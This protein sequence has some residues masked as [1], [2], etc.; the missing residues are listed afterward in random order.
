[1]TTLLIA[2]WKNNVTEP[3]QAT[4]LFE[5]YRDAID[6][7]TNSTAM[8]V[9]CPSANLIRDLGFLVTNASYPDRLQLGSQDIAANSADQE[10]GQMVLAQAGT[11]FVIIGH[12][13]RRW[14][15]GES[16][17]LVNIKLKTALANGFTP[18]VCCGEVTRAAGWQETLTMQI[19]QTLAGIPAKDVARCLIA[20]EPVWAI[21]DT[22]GAR[23]DEPASAAESLALISQVLRDNLA[24]EPLGYLY[25]GSVNKT[26]VAG[27][28]A[29]PAVTGVLVGRAS[30]EPDFSE[31]INLGFNLAK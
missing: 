7:Q 12:S 17:E 8:V 24:A 4:E 21:S 26:N 16:D 23:P 28:L 22:P 31:I 1:M 18:V 29:L 27:F 13:D 6:G 20:Y 2:N 11:R 5:R 14:K 19:Q 9:I 30:L 15:A 25:G 3:R 10:L